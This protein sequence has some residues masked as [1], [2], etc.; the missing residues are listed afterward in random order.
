MLKS[1]MYKNTHSK[2]L[3]NVHTVASRLIST[4]DGCKILYK[5]IKWMQ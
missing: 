4:L 3:Y 1:K 5:N 2:F